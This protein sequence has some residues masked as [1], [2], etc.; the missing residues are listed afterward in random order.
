[1]ITDVVDGGVWS[2]ILILYQTDR[3][4]GDVYQT[5]RSKGDVYQT[6]RS[7]GMCTKVFPKIYV[8]WVW[9]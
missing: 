4:K 9:F 8:R 5:N 3:S 1:M 2:L 7:R 6:D